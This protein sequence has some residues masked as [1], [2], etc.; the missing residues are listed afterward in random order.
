MNVADS[1]SLS[2]GN[3]TSDSPFSM[4]IWLN[5]TSSDS[6]IIMAK[7]GNTN[8]EY[9]LEKGSSNSLIVAL[10]DSTASKYIGA[11]TPANILT[12]YLGTYAHIAVT[13][14]GSG[15]NTG[16]KIYINGSETP[17]TKNS[18]GTYVA[19][20]NTADPLTVSHPT[21]N[22]NGNYDQPIVWNKELSVA[23][24]R[25]AMVLRDM[26]VHSAYANIVSWWEFEDEDISGTT[27]ADKMG[28]N[29]GTLM[30]SATNSKCIA[31]PY[32][33]QLEAENHTPFQNSGDGFS[34]DYDGVNDYSVIPSFAED[35]T[36]ELTVLQWVKYKN[37]TNGA[38][39]TDYLN[40]VINKRPLNSS[41]NSQWQMTVVGSSKSNQ[42]VR[43]LVFYGASGFVNLNT[44]PNGL[45]LTED[46]WHL[47]AMTVKDNDTLSTYLDGKLSGSIS[48][49]KVRN[50]SAQEVVIGKPGYTNSF[51][52]NA[53]FGDSIILNKKLTEAEIKTIYN[54]HQTRDEMEH[55]FSPYIVGYWRGKNSNIGT[56]NI[57]DQSGKGNDGTMYNMTADDVVYKSPRETVDLKNNVEGSFYFDNANDYIEIPDSNSLS[58]G[59]GTSD[60]PFSISL[61][62]KKTIAGTDGLFEKGRYALNGEYELSINPSNFVLFVVTDDSTDG[63]LGRTTSTIASNIGEW[64]HI[65]ATYDG[66]GLNSGLVIYVNG[67]R[68]DTT[69]FSGGTYV[70]ME[71]GAGN[72][73][74]GLKENTGYYAGG[75]MSNVS[76]IG[77]ALSP[78]EVQELYNDGSPVDISHV[79]FA[80]D[81]ISYWG[82]NQNDNPTT[83]GGVIDQVGSNN[84]TGKNMVSG[85]LSTI[86]YPTN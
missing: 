3:G 11:Y 84:G 48:F 76:I 31:Y 63:Y 74:I 30:N 73:R 49:P 33:Y 70:A 78:C 24:I 34:L 57:K 55:E 12:P 66:S 28:T 29:N 17:T 64:V 43:S 82:L 23:E 68:R 75:N 65:V 9:I 5:T 15:L 79:T 61:Y 77:K 19:M 8:R 42:F 52:S 50:K 27:V 38:S 35:N 81:F 45:Y 18:L 69:N 36:D 39:G 6:G 58:F 53:Y 83:T 2:F 40:W 86:D 14:N 67:V 72:A 51:Y 16:L 41:P 85:N 25:E 54:N 22:F 1:N 60:S 62:F 13:Y 7:Y 4:S 46:K 80:S 32:D 37:L 56:G 59:N 71:N 44:T 47:T 21:Y 26:T 10:F 20:S